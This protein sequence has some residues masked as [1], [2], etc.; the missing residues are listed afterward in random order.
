M[1][2]RSISAFPNYIEGGYEGMLVVR[3]ELTSLCSNHHDSKRC[4]IHW[5]YCRIKLLGLSKYTRIAQW[6]A[7]RGTLQEDLNVMIANKNPK[8]LQVV[9]M[10][11]FINR[12]HTV[13]V[14][15]EALKHTSS[16]T[17]TTVLRG[18]F[19]NEPDVRKEFID[20]VK[21]QQEYAQ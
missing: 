16:L 12:Q 15:T 5:Y 4:S 20:N 2:P 1:I 9:N 14:K 21:L 8:K 17:Q 11:V 13:V 10:L 3:S 19:K 7:R 6:C 18:A